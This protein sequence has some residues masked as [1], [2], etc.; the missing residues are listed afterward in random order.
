MFTSEK[1][2]EKGTPFVW[3][4]ECGDVLKTLKH[5]VTSAPILAFPEM[6]KSFV[7]TCDASRSELGYILGQEDA[8]KIERIIEFGRRA[9]HWSEKNYSVS[10]LECLAI[11]EGV[12]TY[13]AYLSTDIP[14]TII[15]DHKALTCLNS[16]A[17]SQNGRLARWALFLQGL[18]L[19]IA[20]V[21]RT[22]LMHFLG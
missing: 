9:L 1:S 20:V 13:R 7:V 8:N 6:N 5:A 11:V 3:S 15:T 19:S 10:E 16:L 14:F 17:I 21:R 2:P 4:Q 22:T 12:R 18:K